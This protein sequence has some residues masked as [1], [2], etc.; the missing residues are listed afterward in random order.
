MSVNETTGDRIT[1]LR[2]KGG[3]S[4]TALSQCA[5]ISKGFLHD[6]E[7]DRRGMGAATLSKISKALGVTMEHLLDG[8]AKTKP[9]VTKNNADLKRRKGHVYGNSHLCK[10]GVSVGSCQ[11]PKEVG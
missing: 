5:E 3:M 11:C 1:R 6:I 7:N 4:M 2:R 9:S 8:E 10:C